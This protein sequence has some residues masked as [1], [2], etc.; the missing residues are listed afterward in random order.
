M[1]ALAPVGVIGSTTPVDNAVTAALSEAGSCANERISWD[2][3]ADNLPQKRTWRWAGYCGR[4]P[5]PHLV[6][7]HCIKCEH[8][9]VSRWCRECLWANQDELLQQRHLGYRAPLLWCL[10]CEQFGEELQVM[11]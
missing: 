8:L 4:T 9:R 3:A 10:E 2:G 11:T 7:Q 5:A 1:N 6:R